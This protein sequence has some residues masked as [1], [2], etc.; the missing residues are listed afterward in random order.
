MSF[1]AD[2]RFGHTQG[3]LCK[4]MQ[5]SVHANNAHV[6]K[7]LLRALEGQIIV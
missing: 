6:L 4:H 3:F 7:H 1:K 5:T 2:A